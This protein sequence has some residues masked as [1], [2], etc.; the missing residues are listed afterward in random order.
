MGCATFLTTDIWLVF[1]Y[2]LCF[3]IYRAVEKHLG[4]IKIVPYILKLGTVAVGLY[5]VFAGCS[6]SFVGTS[7]GRHA[8]DIKAEGLGSVY[9]IIA[10]LLIMALPLYSKYVKFK[11]NE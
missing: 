7:V 8:P 3:I 2:A 5:L 9:M 1:S 6:Q 10:G 11:Q 4:H